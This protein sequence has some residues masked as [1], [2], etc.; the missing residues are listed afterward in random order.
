MYPVII[1]FYTND[2]L[3]PQHANRLRAECT[4]LGLE[5]IIEERPSRG[6]YI[7]NSCIKPE[8][9]RDCLRLGRPVLWIDVDGSICQRPDFF[10]DGYY[11]FQA[12]RMGPHRKRIWHVG[13]MYFNP[14]PATMAFVDAWIDRTGDMT[15][16]SS[17]DQTLKAKDW[18]LRTREVP[19]EYF[20]FCDRHDRPPKGAVIAHRLSKSESKRQQTQ[21][22]N[23]YEREVG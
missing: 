2:W 12:K 6:G 4:K 17:L 11:D 10:L 20:M 23:R 18:G 16:E 19:P 7:Q 5:Y 1:S 14:T 8:F 21:E 15:D 3:Y 13:T 22:F 9:I